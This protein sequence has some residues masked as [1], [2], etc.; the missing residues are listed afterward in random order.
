LDGAAD[1]GTQGRVD[2]IGSDDP[3]QRRHRTER[4]RRRGQRGD[5]RGAR[6]R[7]RGRE[8]GEGPA[9]PRAQLGQWPPGDTERRDVGMKP[10]TVN[11]FGNFGTQNLGNECTL[12]AVI[13]NVRQYLPDAPLRCICTDPEDTSRRYNVTAVAMSSGDRKSTRLN[14][15]HEWISYA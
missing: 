13:H 15:S 11:I 10:S 5:P 8:S 6:P 9:L 3:R 14:S 7:D 4:H 12:Q 2:R 1:A